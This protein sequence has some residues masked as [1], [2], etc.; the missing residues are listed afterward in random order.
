[1]IVQETKNTAAS[2]TSYVTKDGM[3]AAIPY[4]KSN[5]IIIHNG[6]QVHLARTLTTAK[7]YITKEKLKNDK[8]ETNRKC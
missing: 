5:Y 8:C 1:M 2:L 7:T 6:E 4:G 3:W